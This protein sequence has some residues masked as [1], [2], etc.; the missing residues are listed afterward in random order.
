MYHEDLIFSRRS[1]FVE[2]CDSSDELLCYLQERMNQGLVLFYDRNGTRG[3]EQ[4]TRLIR[5]FGFLEN[6][7]FPVCGLH[8]SNNIIEGS[9]KSYLRPEARA[10]MACVAMKWEDLSHRA[11]SL[12]F[13]LTPRLRFELRLK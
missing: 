6:F 11:R 12:G 1:D 13:G 5:K 10:I 9:F 7:S 3:D 8:T 2:E 4:S